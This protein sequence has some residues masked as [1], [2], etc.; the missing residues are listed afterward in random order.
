[1]GTM[2]KQTS[3]DRGSAADDADA[4]TRRPSRVRAI[5]EPMSP[6]R[7]SASQ[8]QLA[9]AL[10]MGLMP[11][12]TSIEPGSEAE[13]VD[14]ATR[15][16]SVVRTHDD[17][18]AAD[19]PPARRLRLTRTA[20]SS[21]PLPEPHAAD[22]M[23]EGAEA[24]EQ[25]EDEHTGSM[26][27]DTLTVDGPLTAESL[28]AWL[29]DVML[30]YGALK[31]FSK[32]QPPKMQEKRHPETG[33]LEGHHLRLV[34]KCQPEKACRQNWVAH[35]GLPTASTPSRI[36]VRVK[37]P[38]GHALSTLEARSPAAAADATTAAAAA[39]SVC[40]QSDADVRDRRRSTGAAV[41]APP[42]QA[43]S[44]IGAAT[45]ASAA[46][47]ASVRPTTV[48]DAALVAA[49]AGIPQAEISELKRVISFQ[50][51]CCS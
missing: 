24:T 44:A 38:A 12:Q 31:Y 18:D 36:P 17:G 49:S 47:V 10:E 8:E 22:S 50:E 42:I 48:S 14:V 20:S 46:A 3:I 35:A 2:P 1:M 7:I 4:S 19:A 45:V 11:T 28:E 29:R 37:I 25:A 23:L 9:R 33:I 6:Y 39:L 43:D 41:A 51:E 30:R 27:M 21:A 13:D 5:A 34:C 26:V 32:R 40:P 15:R 16:T